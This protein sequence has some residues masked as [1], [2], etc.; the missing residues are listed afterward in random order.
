MRRLR[1]CE[2]AVAGLTEQENECK[3]VAVTSRETTRFGEQG[4]PL[5]VRCTTHLC[6]RCARMFDEAMKEIDAEAMA[7]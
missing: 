2:G 1:T 7:S 6:G 5:M 3:E 4:E